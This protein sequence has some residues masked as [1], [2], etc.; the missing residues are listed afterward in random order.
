[1]WGGGGSTKREGGGGMLSLT[2][3][4]RR[5]GVAEQVEALLKGGHDKIWGSFYTV[6]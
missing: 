1:M 3:T 6:A 4:K 5:G 2:P